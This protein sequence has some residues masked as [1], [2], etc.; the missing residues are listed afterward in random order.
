[1]ST[2]PSSLSG[3]AEP[4]VL[5]DH[6]ALDLLNTIAKVDGQDFDFWKSDADV[7]RWLRRV[8]MRP[9]DASSPP[10]KLL[11]AGIKLRELIRGLVEQRKAG[12][13]ID[14]AELNE[15]LRQCASYSQLVMGGE[16]G[17]YLERVHGGETAAQC[18]APIA[19]AA[20]SLLAEGDFELVR[21]CEHPDCSLWFYDRTKSHRRRWCSMAVCGN[22]HKVAEFRKRSAE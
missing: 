8:E 11:A 21:E 19:E 13:E 14:P 6:P 17:P 20:A 4:L 1:M 10:K 7:D 16:D 12:E 2:T 5:A 18:L 15:F 9:D 22:R 3:S